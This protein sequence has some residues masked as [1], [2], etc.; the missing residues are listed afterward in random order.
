MLAYSCLVRP[1]LATL[2]VWWS[3]QPTT[4]WRTLPLDTYPADS[5][6]QIGAAREAAIEQPTSAEAAGQLALVLHAWEQFE[7]AGAAY[8]RA[9]TLAPDD[10]TWWAL[11]GAL[12]SR[13]GAH[14]RAAE[15]F[16]RANAIAPSALLALRHADA[17][18]ESGQ[19]ETAR[20]VYTAAA[21]SSDAEPAAQYGLGRLAMTAGDLT[22]ART[23]LE[24]AVA[25]VPE[26]G[27]AHYAL[28]QLHRKSGNL[29]EARQALARQ[30]QCLACWPMPADPYAARLDAVRTDAAALL[31]QGLVAA[32][33]DQAKGIE[34]HEQALARN[35]AFVQ[36]HVNLITLYG[37]TGNLARTEQ[38]Y[39]AAIASGT[40]LAEAH[41]AFG[42]AL[43]Q[44]GDAARAEPILELAVAANPQ[45]ARA[46]NGLAFIRESSGRLAE[47]EA[48]YRRAVDAKPAD[49]AIR[50][51]LAR[52]L[53]NLGR[54]DDALA[55]LLLLREPNDAESAR[56][57]FAAGAV[58]VRKGNLAEGRRLSEDALSR[59]RRYGLTDLAA[60][61][62]RD[63]AKIR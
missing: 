48:S 9:R 1:L 42:L 4:D 50:F 24:R 36:A 16:G 33:R 8:A 21:R 61:I 14:A 26:F 5:R 3:L 47:A 55:Q 39:Q 12:A 11:S 43:Q 7:A 22:A 2:L 46:H 44:A 53:V 10:A 27:A 58:Y 31:K 13:T 60:S 32:G 40:H 23:A 20:A 17:L 63:L 41:Q 34:L 18:L 15:Y 25:L 57:V 49:R 37:Q 38:H 30:Q 51:G 56:Y 45:D 19:V 28:A 54:L 52:V 29:A 6:A 59:A 62:E 35:P